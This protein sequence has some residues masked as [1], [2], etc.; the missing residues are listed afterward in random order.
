MHTWSKQTNKPN[1]ECSIIGFKPFSEHHA[2]LSCGTSIEYEH[3]INLRGFADINVAKLSKS[4]WYD[5]DYHMNYKN[6]WITYLQENDALVDKLLALPDNIVFTDMFQTTL[7]DS[8]AM[9]LCDIT[10]YLKANI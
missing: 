4:L 7:Y 9:V 8:P 3:H 6:L 5:N 10:N 2:I 1:L